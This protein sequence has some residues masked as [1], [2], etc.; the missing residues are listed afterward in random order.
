MPPLRKPAVWLNKRAVNVLELPLPHQFSS[1]A[2]GWEVEFSG[3]GVIVARFTH[4]GQQQIDTASGD[5]LLGAGEE[6]YFVPKQ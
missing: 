5:R 1:T 4:G 3:T 6:L 2:H